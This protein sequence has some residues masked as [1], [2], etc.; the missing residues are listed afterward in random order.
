MDDT[1]NMIYATFSVYLVLMLFVGM[2]VFRL[3]SGLVKPAYVS[4][5]LLPGT[6][7]SEMAYIF[8]CLI[9]GGEIRRAKLMPDPT[10]GKTGQGAEPTT[11]AAAKLPFVGPLVASLVSMVA[12][13][14]AIYAAKAYLGEVVLN[15]FS[16]NIASG[17]SLPKALPGSSEAF[18][19]QMQKQVSILHRMCDTWGQVPWSNWHVPVFI[20]LTACLSI[21]LAP[22]QRDGRATLTA[23]VVLAA[24]IAL[25]GAVSERCTSLMHDLWPLLTYVWANLLFLLVVSLVLRGVIA[26]V[27]MIKGGK[28]AATTKTAKQAA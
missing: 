20:Y 8:G 16:D 5:A 17:A 12:C 26:L 18:W 1:K 24:G 6:V 14:A 4:W 2:G 11:E 27:L 28:K 22:V 13:A 9:T 3:W 19:D 10:G 21:R 23:V 25:A 7:V 15:A